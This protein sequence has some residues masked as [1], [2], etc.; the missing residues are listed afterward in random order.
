[1]IR[2]LLH[3]SL[4]LRFPSLLKKKD[5]K[6]LGFLV[7]KSSAFISSFIVYMSCLSFFFLIREMSVFHISTDL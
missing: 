1:M 4:L 5:G 6:I 3:P 2:E 7:V